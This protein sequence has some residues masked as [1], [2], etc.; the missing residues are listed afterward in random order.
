MIASFLLAI[1]VTLQFRI[2][3]LFTKQLY[4]PF[5]DSLCFVCVLNVSR[6]E[7]GRNWSVKTASQ[8]DQT[9]GMSRQLVRGDHTLTR[10]CVFGYMQ[11]H[12][13]DQA[14]EILVPG[15]VPD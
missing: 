11:F 15:T 4:Q 13:G 5:D 2:H 8:T 6:V 1:E 3:I 12:Q 10:F 9:R 7:H 14:T